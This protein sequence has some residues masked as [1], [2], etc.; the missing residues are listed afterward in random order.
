[1][2]GGAG[3]PLRPSAHPAA[4]P[5]SPH[6]TANLTP[7]C[8]DPDP[9]VLDAARRDLITEEVD[10]DIQ[11]GNVFKMLKTAFVE[12]VRATRRQRVLVDFLVRAACGGLGWSL[13]SPAR[14]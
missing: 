14:A 9:Q 1:M 2:L 8:G 3:A 10:R 13:R 6:H 11:E 4:R 7:H 5:S 12:G